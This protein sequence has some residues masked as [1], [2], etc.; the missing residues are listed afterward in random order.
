MKKLSILLLSLIFLFNLS[1]SNVQ[2]QYQEDM[3]CRCYCSDKCGPRDSRP[4]D[5]PF[6]DPQTGLCFCKQRDLN[7]FVPHGCDLRA[8]PAEG[9]LTCCE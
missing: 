5:T 8:R 4:D 9:E 1:S 2:A 6:V 7:N 3:P